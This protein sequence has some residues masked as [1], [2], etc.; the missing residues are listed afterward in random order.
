MSDLLESSK[1]LL[2]LD[3]DNALVPHGLGG[4]GRG[5]LSWCVDEVERLRAELADCMEHALMIGAA[6]ASER[7]ACAAK[8]REFS[9]HYEQSSDG[10]NTFVLLAEWIEARSNTSK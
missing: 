5:C 6:V 2:R 3:A 9:E 8:A 4:H 10:R 1:A 7:E